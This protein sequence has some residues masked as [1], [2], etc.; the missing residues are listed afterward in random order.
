[1]GLTVVYKVVEKVSVLSFYRLNLLS[2][3][4]KGPRLHED[5]FCSRPMSS[6]RFEVRYGANDRNRG[7]DQD[8]EAR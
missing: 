4:Q 2:N 5:R 6:Q 1:M 8:L 7:S 3:E